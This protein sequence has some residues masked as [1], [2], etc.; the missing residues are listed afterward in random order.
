[1]STGAA[2]DK[3]VKHL[4]IL[5]LTSIKPD[6]NNQMQQKWGCEQKKKAIA[7]A[8]PGTLG[9]WDGSKLGWLVGANKTHMCAHNHGHRHAHTPRV[10]KKH[11]YKHRGTDN[12][13]GRLLHEHTCRTSLP[14]SLHCP[15]VLN[16]V[17]RW[18]DCDKSRCKKMNANSP[19]R[20]MTRPT[21]CS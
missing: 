12:I 13:P 20:S 5:T 14:S 7:G 6:T 10:I 17:Q 15:L 3:N 2:V 21:V 1:M 18:Y 8:V 9:H 16:L 11:D 19:A 4:G